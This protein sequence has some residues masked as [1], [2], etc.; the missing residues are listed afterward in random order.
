MKMKKTLMTTVAAAALVGFTAM[1][2]AQTM[3]APAGSAAKPESSQTE[4]K[5][6]VGG[7]LKYQGEHPAEKA[8]STDKTAP[9]AGNTAQGSPNAAQPNGAKPDQKMGQSQ[10][11]KTAPQSGAADEHSKT[12]NTGANTA[13]SQGNSGGGKAGGASVALSQDQRSKIGAT[14]GKHPSARVTTDVHF[15][16]SVGATVP[17]S[18]H[19]VTVPEDVIEI[20]PQYEGY[21]YIVVGEQVLIVDP[22]TMEIVAVIDA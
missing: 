20:V 15:N 2:T 19:V 6:N 10:K 13:A 11:P 1:A 5:G 18:V 7:A 22:N 14:I 8:Q 12:G 17:R 21:D 4:Q 9:S 3:Q 16:I